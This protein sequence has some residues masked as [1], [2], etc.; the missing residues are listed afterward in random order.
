MLAPKLNGEIKLSDNSLPVK[1][2]KEGSNNFT[3]R[4]ETIINIFIVL[5]LF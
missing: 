4:S 1:F 2:S 3:A 5:F